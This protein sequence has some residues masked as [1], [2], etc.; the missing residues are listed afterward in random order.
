MISFEGLRS[1][2]AELIYHQIVPEAQLY[3]SLGRYPAQL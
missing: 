3:H 2:S 1:L